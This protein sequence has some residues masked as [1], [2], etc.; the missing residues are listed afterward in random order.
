MFVLSSTRTLRKRRAWFFYST[1]ILICL[2][3]LGKNIIFL[4]LGWSPPSP[5]SSVKTSSSPGSRSSPADNSRGTSTSPPAGNMPRRVESPASR[6]SNRG[7]SHRLIEDA[8][9]GRNSSDRE[10]SVDRIINNKNSHS[11]KKGRA[12]TSPDVFNNNKSIHE[13][14]ESP[15][16]VD[17]DD[18]IDKLN[19]ENIHFDSSSDYF[20]G[21]VT[22][23]S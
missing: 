3:S 2:L 5:A 23:F 8:K 12:P 7:S 1:I 14:N 20:S 13:D 22:I 9:N 15:E 10:G 16:R 17:R 18:N 6:Q 4:P 21:Q 19:E 11:H